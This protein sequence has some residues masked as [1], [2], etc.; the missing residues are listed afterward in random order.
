MALSEIQDISIISTPPKGRKSVETVVEKKAWD[1]IRSVI[2]KEID[3]GGQV[4]F[5]H[6]QV[7]TIDSVKTKLQTLMPDIRFVVGHGQMSGA[8]LEKNVTD[9]YERK[10]DV[11]VCT[12]IIENGID[13]PNVNT[14][15]IDKAQNF[16]LGQLYQLRGRVGRSKIQ[17]YA[18]LFFDGELKQDEDK[19]YIQRLKAIL[20]HQELGAGFG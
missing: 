2:K 11:L 17:A 19:K 18:Y 10:Y 3:R 6:N 16:G 4:Y 8:E 15:I 20:E 9:F 7:R 1:K 12:T 5:V 14:I 13:M